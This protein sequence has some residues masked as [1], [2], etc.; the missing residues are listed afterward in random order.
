METIRKISD[1][2][3]DAA[4]KIANATSHAAENLG[5]KG[6]Q[7]ITMEQQAVKQCRS[8]VSRNPLTAIGIAVSAGFILSQLTRT[9][10]SK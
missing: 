8:Y 5:E 3:E 1:A 6:E 10:S 2:V 9:C 4:E 7:F